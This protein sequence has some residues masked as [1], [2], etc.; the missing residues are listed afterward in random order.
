MHIYMTERTHRRHPATESAHAHVP[1][2]R[3]QLLTRACRKSRGRA[4]PEVVCLLPAAAATS[5]LCMCPERH[6]WQSQRVQGC[7]RTQPTDLWATSECRTHR[8][9]SKAPLPVR[10]S[11]APERQSATGGAHGA[12][13]GGQAAPDDLAD[14]PAPF[15]RR[16]RRSPPHHVA[17]CTSPCRDVAVSRLRLP[18][19]GGS[20]GPRGLAAAAALPRARLY[21][22]AARWV[23]C[24]S[25]APLVRRPSR[26]RC[27]GRCRNGRVAHGARV[28]AARRRAPAPAAGHSRRRA[29]PRSAALRRATFAADALCT[30]PAARTAALRVRQRSLQ[31]DMIF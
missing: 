23:R 1:R 3:R 4:G 19:L 11:R 17:R 13:A 21:G 26:R 31:R 18:P 2:R 16:L 14:G 28:P 24:A 27:R 29:P 9:A 30:Q 15:Y 7:A 6:Q 22:Q 25:C 5:D 10:P 8:P 20:D 12:A